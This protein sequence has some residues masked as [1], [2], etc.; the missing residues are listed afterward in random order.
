MRRP[1]VPVCGGF[2]WGTVTAYFMTEKCGAAVMCALIVSALTA[3]LAFM[4]AGIKKESNK[5][6]I[7]FIAAFTAADERYICI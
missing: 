2:V 1:I 7:L 4:Y 3:L 5:K 6:F